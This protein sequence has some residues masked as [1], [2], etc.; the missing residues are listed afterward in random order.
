M[1]IKV[2]SIARERELE[3]LARTGIDG[4]GLW[5]GIPGG[6][7]ELSRADLVRLAG[8]AHA[9]DVEPVIVT[10]DSDAS[11]VAHSVRDSGAK[12]VQLHAYQLPKVVMELKSSTRGRVLNV[13]KVLHIRGSSCLE[14]RY[15]AA[16]ERA[17]VDAFLLDVATQDGRVGSTGTSLPPDVALDVAERLRVPF[18]L[19]GGISA[20]GGEL[21]EE[22]RRHPGFAGIDVDTAARDA[23]GRLRAARIAA[24]N[25]AWRGVPVR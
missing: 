21:Y 15:I 2:C 13:V 10:F 5:H 11:A 16:Y 8:A 7:A 9:H 23:A 24:I 3:V 18:F 12:W 14:L 22:L 25:E 6:P 17:G 4:A 20:E 19:A 1:K